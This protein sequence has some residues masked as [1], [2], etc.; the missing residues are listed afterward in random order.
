M[1]AAI[2]L[3]SALNTNVYLPNPK[4]ALEKLEPEPVFLLFD[5]VATVVPLKIPSEPEFCAAARNQYRIDA[6]K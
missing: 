1:P 5:A 3:A 6:L 2:A 4:S